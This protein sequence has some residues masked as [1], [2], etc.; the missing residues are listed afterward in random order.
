MAHDNEHDSGGYLA[1]VVED[2][3][4]FRLIYERTLNSV[5]FQV[6]H[7]ADGEQALTFL[8]QH[9]P[10][11]VF[12]DILLPKVKGTVVLQYIRSTEHLKDTY[13]VIVTA[14]NQFNTDES[15]A[16]ADEFLLKPVRPIQ[17]I[18]V[19]ERALSAQSG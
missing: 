1:L 13:V 4:P 3:E 10:H 7:A 15:A 2:D 8:E 5:G 16:L 18:E 19:A 12:L 6:L 17:I 11:V 9:V 14:H